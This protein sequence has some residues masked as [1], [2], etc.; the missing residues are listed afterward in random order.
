MPADGRAAGS[1]SAELSRRADRP[2]RRRH[3]ARRPAARPVPPPERLAVR[4]DLRDAA[5]DA[6]PAGSFPPRSCDGPKG[7]HQDYQIGRTDPAQVL[8]GP[9]RSTVDLQ[10]V[11]R[12]PGTHEAA[13]QDSDA[14]HQ[15][16]EDRRG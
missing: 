4:R 8:H 7:S 14:N 13:D 16:G 1:E 12:R 9:E 3:L 2:S 15:C 11:L 6:L 5:G 10:A